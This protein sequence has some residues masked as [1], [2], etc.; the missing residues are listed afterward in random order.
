M[1][2]ACNDLFI[3]F[4][5]LFY[6]NFLLGNFVSVSLDIKCYRLKCNSVVQ[7]MSQYQ[8][9]EAI[10]YIADDY[11]MAEVDDDMYFRARF[12]A[13]SESDDDDDDEYDHLVSSLNVSKVFSCMVF[14]LNG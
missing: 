14:A 13:E 1:I 10:Y 7:N 11:E 8:G 4:L 3:I 12:M 6:L 9:E 5:F 2:I